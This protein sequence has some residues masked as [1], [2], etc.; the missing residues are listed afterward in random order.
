MTDGARARRRRGV[1]QRVLG[2]EVGREAAGERRGRLHPFDAPPPR[3]CT[4]IE[5]LVD[6]AGLL[7]RCIL[8]GFTRRVYLY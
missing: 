5:H 6:G 7:Q 1:L 4:P 3:L 2:R 8:L